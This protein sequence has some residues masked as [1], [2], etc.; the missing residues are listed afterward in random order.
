MGQRTHDI[1]ESLKTYVD[2][3]DTRL[4][5]NGA[6]SP[7]RWTSAWCNSRHAGKP[8]ANLDTSL[9]SKI[10]SFD[11]SVDG[12][13]KSLEVTFDHGRNP[14]PNHRQPPWHAGVAADRWRAKRSSRSTRA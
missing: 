7:P 8:V 12:R 9:D 4:T 14:S 11:E 10:K 3:F 1:A 6:R 5:S 13:L 2:A